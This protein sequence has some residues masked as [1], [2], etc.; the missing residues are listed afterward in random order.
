MIQ[1]KMKLNDFFKNNPTPG[2]EMT[3]AQTLERIRVHSKFLRAIKADLIT[4]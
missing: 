2:T 3:L 4:K 1:C